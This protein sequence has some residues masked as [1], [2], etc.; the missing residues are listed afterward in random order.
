[1]ETLANKYAWSR[2]TGKRLV[3][4]VLAS[5]LLLV[6]SPILLLTAVL[7][8]CTSPGPVLFRQFRV[9]MGGKSFELLKFRTMIYGQPNLGPGLTPQGD[10]RVFPAGRWLRDRKLDELP[11]FFNVLRGDMSVVGPRPDLPEYVAVL[12]DEQS[13]VLLLR[14]GITGPATLRFRHEE[15]LLAHVPGDKL[16]HFYTSRILPEKVKMDLA[17]ARNATFLSDTYILLRTVAAICR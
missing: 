7:I 11:Q 6:S 14:P 4:L 17:Y 12:T 9:G 3:D 13:E 8:K 10:P 1:M 16:E 15:D 5:L 2:S